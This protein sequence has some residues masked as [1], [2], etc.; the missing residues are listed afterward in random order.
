MSDVTSTGRH[1]KTCRQNVLSGVD[2]PVVPGAAVGARPLTRSEGEGGE[3]MPTGAACL[4]GRVPAVDH[5][6]LAVGL[7]GLVFQHPPEGSPTCIADR[8]SD[9]LLAEL[10]T[11]IGDG[12]PRGIVWPMLANL[13]L[14]I[15]NCAITEEEVAG[16]NEVLAA[17]IVDGDERAIEQL[18]IQVCLAQLQAYL[19]RNKTAQEPR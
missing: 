16:M 14:V 12:T 15:A 10:Q 9:G 1:G 6:E 18:E 5:H 17:L 4:A 13:A 7:F 3:Q 11:R 8:V 2:I 19:D